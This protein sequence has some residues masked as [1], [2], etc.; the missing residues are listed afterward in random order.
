RWDKNPDNY[1]GFLHF[2]CALIA[3]RAAGLF[4]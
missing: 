1:L 2:A 4:G 3:L